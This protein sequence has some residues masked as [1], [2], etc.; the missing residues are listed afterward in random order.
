MAGRLET[1]SFALFG[2]GER[3]NMSSQ[4]RAQE[5]LLAGISA[6]KA[7]NRTEAVPLFRQASEIDAGNETVWLWLAGVS[8][9]P[10]EVLNALE[11]VLELN[12]QNSMALNGI[13]KARLNAGIIAARSDD[14]VRARELLTS[15]C[16]H[17]QDHETAWLWLAAVTDDPAE[18]VQYYERVLTLNPKNEWAASG[19]EQSRTNLLAM[20]SAQTAATEESSS[21]APFLPGDERD[22]LADPIRPSQIDSYQKPPTLTFDDNQAPVVQKEA[23]SQA[24]TKQFFCPICQEITKDKFIT[25]PSCKAVLTLAKVDAALNNPAVVRSKVEEGIS[26]LSLVLRTGQDFFTHYFIGIALLNLGR[27]DDALNHFKAAQRYRADDDAYD[28]MIISLEERRDAFE[29]AARRK[30][31]AEL[32]A[33]KSVLV[34]DDSATI[35]KL[36]G[37]TMNRNGFRVL[38]AGDGQEALERIESDGIP[39]VMLVDDTMPGMDGFTLCKMIRQNPGTSAVPVIMLSSNESFLQKIRGKMV[40]STMNLPKPFQPDTLLKAVQKYCPVQAPVPMTLG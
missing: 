40:G 35:R 7:N 10:L 27:F 12:P 8:A 6:V 19:A 33:K 11:R 37:I 39:D 30:A 24:A 15:V 22:D 25:C 32:K 2:V 4:A 17:Q 13:Q 21:I 16:L 28:D 26:R 38:E 20:N 14:R 36:I 5:L 23:A 1:P 31:A 3:N 9:S 34:V 29:Q 18:A